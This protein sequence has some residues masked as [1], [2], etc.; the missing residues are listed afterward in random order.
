MQSYGGES[1]PQTGWGE[2]LMKYLDEGNIYRTYHRKNSGFPQQ[3]RYE[4]RNLIIDN[5]AMAGRSSKSFR[6][7]QR[8]ADIEAN[9]HEG[10]FLLIQFGHNDADSLKP[11]RF[12]PVDEFEAS[13]MAY[14]EAAF[15]HGA[16]PILVSSI[17]MRPCPENQQGDAGR[18]NGM[19]PEYRRVMEEMSGRYAVPYVDMGALT[20]E[21]CGRIEESE[22]RKLYKEDNVHLVKAGAEAF[23]RLAADEIKKLLSGRF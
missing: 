22:T 20:E 17:T 15:S 6:D 10:D 8:L 12:V 13:L 14:V 16:V 21:L 7:E 18:I 4:S 19:L 5:C 9:I 2:A 23:A 3:I 11:E 1:R